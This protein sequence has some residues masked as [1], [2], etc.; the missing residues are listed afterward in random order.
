M[1]FNQ[2]NIMFFLLNINKIAQ[3]DI[4][5]RKVCVLSIQ[6]YGVKTFVCL[7]NPMSTKFISAITSQV[8]KSYSLIFEISA[9]VSLWPCLLSLPSLLYNRAVSRRFPAF[10]LLPPSV[11]VGRVEWSVCRHSTHTAHWAQNPRQDT[12]KNPLS[13]TSAGWGRSIHTVP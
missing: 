6:E 11:V 13:D 2:M 4:I 1:V 3:R 10:L 7:E 12:V 9:S 8:N 5:S